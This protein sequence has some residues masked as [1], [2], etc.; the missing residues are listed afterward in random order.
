MASYILRKIDDELWHRVKVKAARQS[1]SVKA[2]IERLLVDWLGGE[3]TPP[4]PPT[5]SSGNR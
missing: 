5:E 1:T 3:D 4:M 2:V